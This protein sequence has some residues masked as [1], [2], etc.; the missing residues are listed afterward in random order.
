MSKQKYD[1]NVSK[2]LKKRTMN[3]KTATTNIRPYIG[4]DN[5]LVH[6]KPEPRTAAP[7]FY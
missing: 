5:I 6:A 2:Q 4:L 7:Q 3:R 1:P